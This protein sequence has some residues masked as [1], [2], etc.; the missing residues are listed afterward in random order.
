M[1]DFN[2]QFVDIPLD[3]IQEEWTTL[4]DSDIPAIVE[5]FFVGAEEIFNI[6]TQ[7]INGNTARANM[8]FT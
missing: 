8:L 7:F 3:S 4:F 6:F 2:A 5:Q 1:L